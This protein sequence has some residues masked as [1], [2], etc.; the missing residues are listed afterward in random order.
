MD[1]NNYTYTGENPFKLTPKE[2]ALELYETFQR[3][4]FKMSDYSTIYI[5]TAIYHAILCVDEILK[6]IKETTDQEILIP[7]VIY[8]E[9]VKQELEVL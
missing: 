3:K 5:S 8:W 9:K 7:R 4:S 6:E 1:I 2:K